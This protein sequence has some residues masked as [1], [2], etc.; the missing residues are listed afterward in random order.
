MAD[1]DAAKWEP[2]G[3]M[4][5][6]ERHAYTFDNEM[7]A[8]VLFEVDAEDGEMVQRT[9]HKYV[10]SWK[11]PF[12]EAH[13][14]GKMMEGDGSATGDGATMIRI[15]DVGNQFCAEMLR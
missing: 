8:D 15:T 9:A 12:F 2:D 5:A 3:E 7:S 1:A 6:V 10:L 4:A 14:C 13:V 11:S